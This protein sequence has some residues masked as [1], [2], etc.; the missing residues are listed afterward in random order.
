MNNTDKQMLEL[1]AKSAGILFNPTANVKGG[2]LCAHEC[3]QGKTFIWNPLTDDGDALRL[4]VKMAQLTSFC[5][6][7]RLFIKAFR[8]EEHF[9]VNDGCLPTRRAIVR[10]AADA[11][12]YL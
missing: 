11:G 6:F 10:A 3:D 1:A 9:S 2:L 4:A 5:R 12:K 8:T 7:M